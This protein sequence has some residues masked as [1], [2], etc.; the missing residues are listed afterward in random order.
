MVDLKKNKGERWIV[1]NRV[2]IIII[3][4]I[5]FFAFM[6]A[7]NVKGLRALDSTY[8]DA[9]GWTPEDN[10]WRIYWDT[11]QPLYVLLWMG[12]AAIIGII[13]YQ[14]TKD[15]SESIALFIVPAILIFF[16]TQDLLYYLFSP[17]KIIN[18]GCWADILLPVK[19]ISN[20]FGETCPTQ[21]SFA[22]SG[23]IGLAIGT[24]TLYKLK[25]Y[26]SKRKSK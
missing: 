19:I 23:V 16:G 14:F 13:Y 12:I 25:Y 17:D 6:D 9:N 18:T 21:A 26:D 22:T 11:I 24:F 20:W 3:I 2:L 10:I 4:M 8:Q 1:F 5:A 7:Q 15:K